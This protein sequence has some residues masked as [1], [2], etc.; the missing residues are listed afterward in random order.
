MDLGLF[1]RKKR[2]E[3]E[4]SEVGGQK[5]EEREIQVLFKQRKELG[6]VLI[7]A[8][9]CIQ[10]GGHSNAAHTGGLQLLDVV[11][12]TIFNRVKLFFHAYL[13]FQ[14]EM[15]VY[16]MYNVHYFKPP[17]GHIHFL[18]MLPLAD[19]DWIEPDSWYV[20]FIRLKQSGSHGE[21][22]LLSTATTTHTVIIT[23]ETYALDQ[24]A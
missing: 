24:Q 9:A 17:S 13:G 23:M 19:E 16:N 5:E 8:Q 20:L 14:W 3:V 22:C 1:F 7:S 21:L 4:R 18:R 2:K 15:C 6:F 10:G 12:Y 11:D